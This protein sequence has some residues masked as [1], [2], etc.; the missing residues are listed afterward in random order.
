M[1]GAEVSTSKLTPLSCQASLGKWRHLF[2]GYRTQKA[3][4]MVTTYPLSS[5]QCH[6]SQVMNSTWR[7]HPQASP[8]PVPPSSPIPHPPPRLSRG[9]PPPPMAATPRLA[10]PLPG[11]RHFAA[12]ATSNRRTGKKHPGKAI[13][14]GEEQG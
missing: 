8:A 6:K 13:L 7:K 10:P 5:F 3:C 1:N 11:T 4:I 2:F 9:M 14:A 12:A